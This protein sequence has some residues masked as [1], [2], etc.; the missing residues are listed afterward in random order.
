MVEWKTSVRRKVGDGGV[1][2]QKGDEE[3]LGSLFDDEREHE[4]EG[5]DEADKMMLPGHG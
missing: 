1:H 2:H 3:R 4:E 5:N